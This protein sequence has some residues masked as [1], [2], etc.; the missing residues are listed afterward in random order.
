MNARKKIG[1]AGMMLS[2][3]VMCLPVIAD[4]IGSGRHGT[5][6]GTTPPETT[7]ESC[8]STLECAWQELLD[9]FEMETK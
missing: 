9:I 2:G 7:T 3:S 1:V 5:D 4:D 8:T 6:P